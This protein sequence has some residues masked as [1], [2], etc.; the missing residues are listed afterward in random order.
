MWTHGTP[1]FSHTNVVSMAHLL[2]LSS[3]KHVILTKL[4]HNLYEFFKVIALLLNF[5]LNDF[6]SRSVRGF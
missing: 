6:S 4:N 2:Q 1:F 5:S 3:S